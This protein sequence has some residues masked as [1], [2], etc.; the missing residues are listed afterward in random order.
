MIVWKTLEDHIVTSDC[1]RHHVWIL[2]HLLRL[3]TSSTPWP[4]LSVSK[5]TASE[6][7]AEETNSEETG[8]CC[9]MAGLFIIWRRSEPT[10]YMTTSQKSRFVQERKPQ[11]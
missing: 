10:E 2:H 7:F 6:D 11:K 8:T 5:I 4:H 1:L 9:I 3:A